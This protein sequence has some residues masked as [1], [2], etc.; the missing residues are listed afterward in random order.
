[1]DY[2]NGKVFKDE[3]SIIA[4]KKRDQDRKEI[5]DFNKEEAQQ[6]KGYEEIKLLGDKL[7]KRD[8]KLL[9]IFILIALCYIALTK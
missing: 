7:Y 5:E 8:I 3:Q 6:K 4:Q 1:M 2:K 9:L